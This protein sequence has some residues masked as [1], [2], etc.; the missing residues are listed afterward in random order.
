MESLSLPAQRSHDTTVIQLE[1]GL[2]RKGPRR[3][4]EFI[5]EERKDAVYWEKR[6][7]NNE[8]AKRSRHKRRLNDFALET[9]L[10]ALKEENAKLSAELTSIKLH[11]GLAHS[12]AL[13]SRQ[14]N[15]LLSHSS[16]QPMTSTSAYHQFLQRNHYWAGKDSSTIPNH[17]PSHP[18]LVPTYTLHSM[19][20]YSY[21]N[22]AAAPGPGILS[23]LILPRHLLPMYSADPGAPLLKPIPT[24]AAS[25]EDE[26]QQVP[27]L[28]YYSAPHPKNTPGRDKKCSPQKQYISD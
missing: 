12:A 26:E 6:H 1:N 19:K 24:R 11:F 4:R 16:T 27:G 25:D 18:F 2:A 14:S 15:Q 28:L 9:H 3:K 10:T 22:P 20:G 8:A 13:T 7:K 5:P 21:L 17:Q 23:H